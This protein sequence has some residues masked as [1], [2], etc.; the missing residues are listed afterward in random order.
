MPPAKRRS[1]SANDPMMLLLGQ[2]DGKLDGLSETMRRHIREDNDSLRSIDGR[3][4]GLEVGA[5]S[6][7]EQ[8]GNDE[9]LRALERFKWKAAGAIGLAGFLIG[10]VA[11]LLHG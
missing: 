4:R 10:I 7:E 2:I 11:K 5:P 6:A 3:L 1:A 9:R 8:R